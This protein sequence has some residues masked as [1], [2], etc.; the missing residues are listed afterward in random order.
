MFKNSY[1][2]VLMNFYQGNKKKFLF[3]KNILNKN[4]LLKKLTSEQS[5]NY[6]FP[7]IYKKEF[8]IN[9]NIFFEKLRYAE[10]L[11]FITKV[12]SLVKNFYI[13]NDSIIKHDFNHNGLSSQI[14]IKNDSSYL[15]AINLLEKFENN[16]FS[17]TKVVKKY[18][19]S[20]KKFC[21]YQFLL[22]MLK[23]EINTIIKYNKKIINTSGKLKINNNFYSKKKI[24][25]LIFEILI[26][27]NKILNFLKNKKNNSIALYGYG[28]IGKS[29]EKFLKKNEFKKL[30]FLDDENSQSKIFKLQL[31][32]KKE[33][34]KINKF[35]I[36][37]PDYKVYK[38]IYLNLRRQKIKRQI[39]MSYFF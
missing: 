1:D 26:L 10:D 7:Y 8:L 37:V 17:L 29:L 38:K 24:I 39:I 27:K 32:K 28:V 25:D 6:C 18:I 9:K 23:Y 5:V 2:L 34:L 30:I 33:I 16:K 20:K 36:C 11:I 31:M 4:L 15:K 13:L 21:F 14:S 3:S 22:R 35:I 19:V 12:F